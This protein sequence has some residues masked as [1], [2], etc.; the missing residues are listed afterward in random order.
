MKKEEKNKNKVVVYCIVS[1]VILAM[2]IGLALKFPNL[3]WYDWLISLSTIAIAIYC[4][5]MVKFKM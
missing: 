5:F 3:V 2:I 4:M 1:L